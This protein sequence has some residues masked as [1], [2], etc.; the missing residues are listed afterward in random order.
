VCRRAVFTNASLFTNRGG[1]SYSHVPADG[2]AN[3]AAKTIGPIGVSTSRPSGSCPNNDRVKLRYRK[4][5]VVTTT[6]VSAPSVGKAP[7]L[8]L[9]TALVKVAVGVREQFQSACSGVWGAGTSTCTSSKGQVATATSTRA[10]MASSTT[11]T[12]QSRRA[13]RNILVCTDVHWHICM[14]GFMH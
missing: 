4:V 3:L 12:T 9:L 6:G 1:P 7:L 5:A 2:G 13:P 14:H 10:V 8:P 11:A